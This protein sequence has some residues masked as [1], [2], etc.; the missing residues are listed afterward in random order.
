[1]LMLKGLVRSLFQIGLFAAVLLI[2]AGTWHW[3]RAIQF[4][5]VFALLSSILIV[6]LARWA[7]AS[8]EARIQRGAAKNQPAADRIASLFI[9]LL[10]LFWFVF[11]AID[12]HRLHLLPL[13]PL[14]LS[15]VGA[16]VG[17]TGYG[18]M[19]TAV[20]QNPYAAPIVGD[21]TD[22]DQVVIDSGLY[23]RVRHPLYL[24]YILF[25]TGLGLWLGSVVSALVMPIIVA[26]IVARILIEEKT[27]RE[28][29]PGYAEYMT[30][31]PYRL[32]P[33]AW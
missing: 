14:W 10:N 2:P 29:L 32:V 33:L 13:P 1:M 21:Q 16:V 28:N 7:P 17:L 23:G 30:R 8:L 15:A 26:P 4:L 25:L 19:A 6:S 12:V 20:W 24:G 9:V 5:V 3:P 27:L 31:V 18:V 11:V 22:R